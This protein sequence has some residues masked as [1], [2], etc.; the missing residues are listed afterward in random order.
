V[1]PVITTSFGFIIPNL[2]ESTV[3]T[4]LPT[5][6]RTSACRRRSVSSTWTQ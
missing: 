3:E 6:G 4:D 5:A 1:A 2:L